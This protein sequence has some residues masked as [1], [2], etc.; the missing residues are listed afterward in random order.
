MPQP[1]LV[2]MNPDLCT[3]PV[4]GPDKTVEEQLREVV[5]KLA[6]EQ[7]R[8]DMFQVMV[9]R[10]IPTNEVRNFIAGQLDMKRTTK[11]IDKGIVKTVMRSKLKDS[12]ANTARLGQQRATLK[13]KLLRKY[14]DRRHTARELR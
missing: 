3:G 2:E 10:N 13:M 6:E 12:Y 11:N 4:K 9:K 7:S 8:T 14:K 1:C 5:Y